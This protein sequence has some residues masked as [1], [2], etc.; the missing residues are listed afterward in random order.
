[1]TSH[2]PLA[3]IDA[4]SSAG[5]YGPGQEQAPAAFRRHG[6]LTALGTVR[7]LHDRGTAARSTFRRAGH[8][9]ANNAEEVQRVAHA[10]SRAVHAALADGEDVLTLGGD[11]TIELGVVAAALRHT[12]SVGLVYVDLDADLTT[13]RTGD[14]ILDWM[15]V[16]HLLALDDTHPGI[17]TLG[18][19]QPMLAPPDIVLMALGRATEPEQRLIDSLDLAVET[20]AV[21]RADLSAVLARTAAWAA[22]Y[23]VV[24]I[25]LDADVLSYDDLA[26]ADNTRRVDGLTV[27]EL[28]QLLVGLLALP[29]VRGLSICEVNPEHATDQHGAISRLIALLTAGLNRP[30]PE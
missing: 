7:E 23:E 13:T 15:G 26:I 8:Q 28:E 5:A 20:L 2:R 30:T 25:H 16:A 4:A 10:L 24:L 18:P 3:I 9:D 29:P 21:V 19:R 22:H 6:L 27:D 12:P 1:M 11:C 17:A 14:G